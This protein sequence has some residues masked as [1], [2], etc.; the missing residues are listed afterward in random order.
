MT[1]M[2]Q[3]IENALNDKHILKIMNQASKRFNRQLDRDTIYSC[4]LNALWNAFLHFNPQMGAKFTTYLYNGV[5][6]ECLKEIKFRNKNK[7]TVKLH[8]NIASKHNPYLLI[9]LFDEVTNPEER[10]L[11]VD[12]YSNMTI[13]EMA[14][15]R[16]SNR[17]TTRKKLKKVLQKIEQKL[18]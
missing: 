7:C 6:I 1:S 16:N 13:N 12:K 5:F 9:D 11:L 8:D 18:K 14:E 15:A 4:H 10:Q 17:E 2:D 3:K